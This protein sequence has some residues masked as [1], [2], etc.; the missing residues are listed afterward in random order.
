[1][2][3]YYTLEEIAQILKVH[4]ETVRRYIRKGDLKAARIGKEYRVREDDLN[5][6]YES[7]KKAS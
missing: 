4:R 3:K 2:Q 7:K 5:T 1:M 6:F